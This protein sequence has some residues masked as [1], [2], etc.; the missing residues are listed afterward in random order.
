MSMHIEKSLNKVIKCPHLGTFQN[1]NNMLDKFVLQQ[2]PCPV[3]IN[4]GVV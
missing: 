1:V 4:A 3:K 2:K